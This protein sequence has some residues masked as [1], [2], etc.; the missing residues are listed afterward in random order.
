[1][2]D[3]EEDTGKSFLLK[4]AM[5]RC[6]IILRNSKKPL[7]DLRVY[8]ISPDESLLE[9]MAIE[10]KAFEFFG[11]HLISLP[12]NEIT[13]KDQLALDDSSTHPNV[14][15]LTP[16]KL[17]NLFYT[18]LEKHFIF[19]NRPKLVAYNC[20]ATATDRSTGTCHFFQCLYMIRIFSAVVYFY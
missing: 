14:F 20:G 6:L 17:V 13:L 4:L 11:L 3:V 15:F 12:S 18:N 9:R 7:T 19:Q 16:R 5:I 10:M 2:I 1:M 8:Y